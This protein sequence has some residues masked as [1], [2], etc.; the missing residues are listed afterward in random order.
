MD[1]I[2]SQNAALTK[3]KSELFTL[4]KGNIRTNTAHYM[5]THL[6]NN[7]GQFVDSVV[8]GALVSILIIYLPE[9]W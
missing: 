7:P 3:G 1:Q 8:Y 4:A 2:K 5:N 6:H 9:Q